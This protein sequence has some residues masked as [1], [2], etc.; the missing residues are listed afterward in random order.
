MSFQRQLLLWL[1][2][3]FSVILST[4]VFAADTQAWKLRSVY[5]TMTDRFARTDG[6]TTQ[7]CNTTQGLYCGGTW[8]GMISRLDYIQ[9]MGFDAVMI[10]PIIKNIDGRVSYGE[11]YHGYWAEDLYSLN[12]H[13]GTHQDLLDLSRALHDRGMYLMVDTVI[14][15]MAYITHGGNP[16]TDVNYTTF[17]PFNGPQYY[18]PYCKINDYNNYPE[19]Q[20]CWTGDNIVALPDLK[21]EDEQVQS[22]LNKWIQDMIS[23]YSIDGLRLDAAKHVTPDFL[24]KFQEAANAFI[25]GEVYEKSIDIVCSYQKELTS[26]PNYPIYFALLDAFTKG[27]TSTLPDEVEVMKHS[28]PNVTALTT[29]SENH[30]VARFASM[31]D[32]MNLAKNILTFTILFDGIPMVYQGQEQHFSGA[33]DPENREALWLSNYNT[34]APLYNVIKTL[35]RLRKHAIQIDPNYIDTQTY[36][37]YRGPSEMGF[38]KGREGRQIVMVLSTQGSKSGEYTIRMMN[39]YQPSYVVID[40]FTCRTYTVNDMGELRLEMDKGEPRVLY[41]VNLM[42]GSG[43]CGYGTAKVTYLDFVRNQSSPS[44]TPTSSEGWVPRGDLQESCNSYAYS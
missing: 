6:S 15:N 5:Q 32:D 10:S 8:R 44:P 18:H 36:P 28:C 35:N 43:L 21:T 9:G 34:D 1:C 24:P 23:T 30:D 2:A 38:R 14:N 29:F 40:V 7:A 25:T 4:P 27:N 33:H 39:G 11:A 3:S 16:A 13:F 37:V 22:V 41:P 17:K 20:Q 19:A 12:P 31:Q 42:Y 26:V